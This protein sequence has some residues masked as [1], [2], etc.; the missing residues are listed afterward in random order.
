MQGRQILTQTQLQQHVTQLATQDIIWAPLYDSNQYVGTTG[1]LNLTFFLQP[2]GSGVTS[3][4]GASGLKSIA[5]TNMTAAGQLTQGNDFFMVGQEI[6]FYPGVN[7]EQTL[8]AAGAAATEGFAND[9]YVFSK[10]GVLTLAIGSNRQYIQ[11]GPAAMFPPLTR[12]AG[13][14]A[15]AGGEPGTGTQNLSEVSYAAMGG[16]PYN[17][18][19]VYITATLGFNET[20]SYPA[21]VTLPSGTNARVFSSLDGWLIRNAQ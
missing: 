10:A 3:A 5:D 20:L 9:T 1:H 4:P 16:A 7:P 14:A 8:L 18:T 13:W 11:D 21:A 2:I 6:V 17:I 12:L 15:L 19:P